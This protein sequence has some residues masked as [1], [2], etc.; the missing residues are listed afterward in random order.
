MKYLAVENCLVEIFKWTQIINISHL[1]SSTS[2]TSSAKL[3]PTTRRT[4]ACRGEDEKVSLFRWDSR[5]Q[6]SYE[7]SESPVSTGK[8]IFRVIFI[9]SMKDTNHLL[10]SLSQ[11]L[12]DP[13]VFLY[14]LFLK[15]AYRVESV[16]AKRTI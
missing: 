15:V 9:S 10:A 8:C 14:N 12:L 7:I 16:S 5:W 1:F 6:N 2:S 11:W 4:L 3:S 13:D